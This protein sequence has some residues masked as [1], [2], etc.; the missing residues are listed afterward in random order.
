MP[1]KE[2]RI[3]DQL[4]IPRRDSI[5]PNSGEL[6]VIFKTLS[7]PVISVERA[8][9]K[10]VPRVRRLARA[11]SENTMRDLIDMPGFA[12]V[13]NL[14]ANDSTHKFDKH[15]ETPDISHAHIVMSC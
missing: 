12:L 8:T 11:E 1:T 15:S 13:G 14:P 5:H 2:E 6:T 4:E 9:A 7:G 10:V 3:A